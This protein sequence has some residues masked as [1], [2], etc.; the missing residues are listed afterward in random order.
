VS[1]SKTIAR[2]ITSLARGALFVAARAPG[3]ALT[4]HVRS[5]EYYLRLVKVVREHGPREA[6]HRLARKLRKTSAR[7]PEPP[8]P[9]SLEQL[10]WVFLGDGAAP[11]SGDFHVLIVSHE[12]TRTGAPLILL[13]LARELVRRGKCAVRVVLQRPGEIADDFA[14]CAPT[15]K[16]ADL[17]ALG[18]QR[19]EAPELVAA[20]FRKHAGRGVALCNTVCVSDYCAAF[21]RHDVPVLAWLHE[22]PT[23]IE[24][25]GRGAPLVEQIVAAS[26]RI[27]TPSRFVR[28][29][30]MQR[31]GIDPGQI[32]AVHNG[33]AAAPDLANREEARAR[34]REELGLLSSARVVLGCGT[35]ELRKG[36]DLF[37]QAAR[38]MLSAGLDDAWFIWLGAARDAELA[39]WAA[40]DAGVGMREARVRFVG[41]RANV[42]PYFLGADLF[43]LTSREEPFPLVNLEAL[44][45]GLPVVAFEGAGGAVEVLEGAG[46]VV[47]YLDVAAMARAALDLLTKPARLEMARRRALET[48][49]G[50]LSWKCFAEAMVAVLRTDFGYEEPPAEFSPCPPGLSPD[51]LDR[52]LAA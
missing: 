14:R 7:P 26:R 38:Q 5:L 40:H 16:Q 44:A 31:Y 52:P 43:L 50:Q 13:A 39:T 29:S 19:N 32:V 47:P 34:V 24:S 41:P 25:I 49:R 51:N 27:I 23:C 18:V 1:S 46:A 20:L 2:V 35:L 28:R 30:L 17:L 12:A 22:L 10:P 21:A 42:F 36:A 37:V 4:L 9:S 3:A 8:R 11:T 15:L 48:A 33:I 45:S 6:I